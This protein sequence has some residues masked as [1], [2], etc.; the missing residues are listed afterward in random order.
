M[1]EKEKKVNRRDYLKYTGAGI[2]GLIVGGALGYLLKPSEVIKETVTAPGVVSTVTAEK[3]VTVAGPTVM[4]TKTFTTEKTVA[5]VTTEPLKFAYLV[6]GPSNPY[7]LPI[8]EG[9]DDA[10]RMVNA[11]TDF[12]GPAEF[13]VTKYN[14]LIY[15][16][17]E[18]KYDGLICAMWDTSVYTPCRE[19]MK[20]GIPVICW[21]ALAYPLPDPKVKPIPYLS[22]V[23]QDQVAAGHM[24][25]DYIVANLI[26][27]GDGTAVIVT[28]T[29]GEYATDLRAKSIRERL[30]ELGVKTDFIG[31]HTADPTKCAEQVS[32]YLD[33]HPEA[34]GFF[35]V[36]GNS[37][38]IGVVIEERGLK[39]K[40]F[41]GGFDLTP[42]MLEFIQKGIMSYT[43]DQQ[44]YFQGFLPILMLWKHVTSHGAYIPCDVNTGK[45]LV[46]KENID[47]VLKYRP[48]G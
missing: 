48:K 46:T 39:G 16:C 19:A 6:I 22:Y 13:D 27:P 38:G 15:T 4:T 33:G 29:L 30:E 20:A 23:G 24:A 34:K 37:W 47:I 25:A 1:G 31:S 17:I 18:K 11:T 14:D 43:V 28:T 45:S 10:S 32:S 35:G 44:P 40:V 9:K 2:G 12:L 42:K 21:G 3:T 7:Y 8:I 41:G 26:S 36:D 5:P